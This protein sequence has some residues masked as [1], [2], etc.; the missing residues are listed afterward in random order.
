MATSATAVATAASTPKT[1]PKGNPASR[2]G[3]IT[4]S[5]PT[6]PIRTAAHRP[7]VTCSP[8]KTIDSSVMNSGAEYVSAVAVDNGNS[9]TAPKLRNSDATPATDRRR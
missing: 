6:N 1:L 2:S 8:S 9:E 4:I 3:W 5:M 7:S